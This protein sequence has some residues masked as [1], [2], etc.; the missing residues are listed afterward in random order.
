LARKLKNIVLVQPKLVV[1][2]SKD[3][4]SLIWKIPLPSVTEQ[5]RIVSRIEA[6][7]AASPWPQ[8]LRK[9][10]SEETEAFLYSM[11]NSIF[12]TLPFPYRAIG[13]LCE[14][15]SGGTP[16]RSRADFFEGIFLGLNP[17]NW[18]IALYATPKNIS[19]KRQ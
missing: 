4:F 18:K 13:D 5:Y 8:S 6:L 2:V 3:R 16:S 19:L 9:E 11:L 1:I 15:T 10:A 7:A 12:N 17:A 14:T